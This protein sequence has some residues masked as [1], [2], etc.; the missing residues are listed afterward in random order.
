VAWSFRPPGAAS[1][2][3]LLVPRG[4]AGPRGRA[5]ES[6]IASSSR[7]TRTSVRRPTKGRGGS[8]A[9][10]RRRGTGRGVRPTDGGAV[11]SLTV[12]GATVARG[13]VT[14]RPPEGRESAIGASWRRLGAPL[15]GRLARRRQTAA[16]RALG[17]AV[18]GCGRHG[19]ASRA[20]S[21]QATCTRCRVPPRA[22]ARR[23]A[24]LVNRDRGARAWRCASRRRGG[25]VSEHR[26]LNFALALHGVK[27]VA[28]EIFRH[29]E[30]PV[31]RPW[32]AR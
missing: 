12:I 16:G 28:R 15:V 4:G 11:A 27:Q 3:A 9:R 21:G 26:S 24:G 31:P 10:A 6:T 2:V 19:A 20:P 29:G 7:S 18:G 32:S 17:R 5:A 8:P 23:V 30:S 22:A 25:K 13:A 14:T 1:I